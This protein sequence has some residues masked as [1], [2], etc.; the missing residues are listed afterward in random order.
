MTTIATLPYGKIPFKKPCYLFALVAGDL[1]VLADR[2]T[3]VSGRDVA[4]KIYSEKENIPL[5]SHAMTSLKQSMAWDEK[6]FGREYDLDLYQIVAIN[7][8]NAGAMEN[9]G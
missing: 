7:D 8:F 1:A 5:C 2:F 4:L 3:T 9:K 6:R